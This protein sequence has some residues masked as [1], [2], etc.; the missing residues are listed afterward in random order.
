MPDPSNHTVPDGDYYAGIDFANREH[1]TGR[2]FVHDDTSTL[3]VKLQHPQPPCVKATGVDCPF[4]TSAEFYDLLTGNIPI[5]PQDG[6]FE[7]RATER[8]VRHMIGEEYESVRLWDAAAREEHGRTFYYH[9]TS[10][11]QPS[12][13]LRIV[14]SCLYWLATLPES[15]GEPLAKLQEARRGDGCVVEAHPRLFLY[16]MIERVYRARNDAVTTS[17]LNSVASYKDRRTES[18]YS[19]RERVYAFLHSNAYLWA[20]RRLEPAEAPRELLDSDHTFDAWL[21]ALTAWATAQE[22]TIRWNAA[23][24]DQHRVDIE[25]HI[26]I[27]DHRGSSR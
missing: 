12:V 9:P 5:I 19:Q 11:I 6:S 2:C 4:G 24:L 27:L 13:G 16:S 3:T 7:L 1:R 14:P 26:L 20:E 8:W 15:P 21:S 22:M 18:H 23:N 17:L 10:H 25:G